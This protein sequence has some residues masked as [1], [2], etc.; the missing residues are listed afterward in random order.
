MNPPTIVNPPLSPSIED[1]A[2][3]TAAAIPPYTGRTIG[4]CQSPVYLPAP[5]LEIVVSRQAD[6]R[7]QACLANDSEDVSATRD[8]HAEAVGAL[9]WI[10]RDLFNIK[11]TLK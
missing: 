10:Y 3:E 2:S 11:I 1:S 6:N 7:F 5:P 8:S 4:A 9:V